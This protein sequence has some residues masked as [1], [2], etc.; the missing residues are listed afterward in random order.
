MAKLNDEI[1]KTLN[2]LEEAEL[3]PLHTVTAIQAREYF[4]A[5]REPAK[6]PIDVHSI[7]DTIV[8]HDGHRVPVRIYRPVDQAALPA[9]VWIH[10][11]GWVL[12]DLDTADLPCRDLCAFSGCT[13]I[14]V[15]YRLAPE[16][17]FPA[18]FDDCMAVTLWACAHAGELG[19]DSNRIAVGGD[20]AGGNLAACV[21]LNAKNT[22]TAL[23]AQL[24][25]YPVIDDDFS[26]RSYT[27][28][29]QGYFLTNDMMQWFWDQYVPVKSDRTD[30]RVNPLH[31]DLSK[32]P[33][34][35]VLTV[36][37]DPLR[38]EGLAYAA[39]LQ[40]HNVPVH[41][42]HSEDTIHGYFGMDLS[43]GRESRREVA[44]WLRE[45]VT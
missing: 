18:A 9:L 15:D 31:S 30:A 2:A 43:C 41:T 1:K 24:L 29:A 14:S 4:A 6:E 44:H 21:A 39:A 8:N 19:I 7:T 45:L 11:G 22:G 34:A 23:C 10:G 13:V 25:V 3:P 28:N 5:L 40:K 27:E 42:I 12:G 33:P 36:E 20:S 38:D 35:I 26:N 32:L 37:K 16:A 17:L